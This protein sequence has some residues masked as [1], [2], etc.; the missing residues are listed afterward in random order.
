MTEP[1]PGGLA[2][3]RQGKIYVAGH[4]GMVGSALVRRLQ[5]AGCENLLLKTRTQVDLED[6]R[7][8]SDFIQM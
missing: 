3:L 8:L 4:L 6:Q 2:A 5:N 7:Q 1:H